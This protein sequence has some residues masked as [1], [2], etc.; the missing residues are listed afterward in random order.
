[1][2]HLPLRAEA[3]T[4]DPPAPPQRLPL[5]EGRPGG[6]LERLRRT[7][8]LRVELAILALCF[9]AWQGLRLPFEGAQSEALANTRAWLAIE[10]TLSLDVEPA[11]IRSVHGHELMNRLAGLAYGTL[12]VPVVV[13][14]LVAA[15]LRCPRRYP[16]LRLTFVLGHVPA[17]VVLAAYPLAP[18]AW[19]VGMPFAVGPPA[20]DELLRNATAAVVSLHFG[21]SVFVAGAALWLWPRSRLAWASLLYPPLVFSVIVTTG[22]HYVLDALVGTACV[23]LAAAVARV[24]IG[25]APRHGPETAGRR[26]TAL[27]ALA[28]ALVGAAANALA[29]G[30]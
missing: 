25:P 2:T 9:L 27:A 13:G 29:T 12:H 24:V 18:P 6:L 28:A 30:L 4:T 1:M 15:R 26:Y 23:V 5:L 20:H 21:Y 10:R 8:S 3:S 17:L 7:Y 11:L 19:L 14:L 22:N 16:T